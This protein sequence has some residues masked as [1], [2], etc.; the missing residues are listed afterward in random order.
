MLIYY[1]LQS[2]QHSSQAYQIVADTF[3]LSEPPLG[4]SEGPKDKVIAEVCLLNK[5]SCFNVFSLFIDNLLSILDIVRDISF[6]KVFL[7][8]Y[9]LGFNDLPKIINIYFYNST[10]ETIRLLNFDLLFSITRVH[11]HQQ[12]VLKHPLNMIVA[13]MILWKILQK[14]PSL[15]NVLFIWVYLAKIP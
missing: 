5:T 12:S 9:R 6:F 15:L 4:F 3:K 14:F 11:L 1:F 8:T 10:L 13:I 2:L 7:T